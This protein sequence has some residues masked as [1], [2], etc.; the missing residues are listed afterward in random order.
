MTRS[1]TPEPLTAEAF[2]P[3]GDVI[4]AASAS[5]T[6]VLNDGNTVCARDLAKIDV[7][8]DD[9]SACVSIFRT[10]PLPLPLTLQ[11]MERHP[12]GSQAFIPMGPHPYLVVVAPPG[13][14]DE[15]A[16]RVFLARHD[17]GINYARGAWHHYSLALEG[18]SDFLLIDRAGPGNN[19]DEVALE[20]P[21]HVN[22]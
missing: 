12:L 17:Q 21:I 8:T 22:L 4:D 16:I 14:F 13:E 2:S 20:I 3:F 9:G 5:E 6:L 19:C 15:T 18:A 1:L 11:M 10:N 7:S